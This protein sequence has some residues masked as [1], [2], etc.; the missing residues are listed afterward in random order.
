MDVITFDA[1]A[2]DTLS[3]GSVIELARRAGVLVEEE[4]QFPDL[5]RVRLKRNVYAT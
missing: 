4:R 5:V 3:D 2:I 1:A